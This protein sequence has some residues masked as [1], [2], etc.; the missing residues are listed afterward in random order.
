[1]PLITDSEMEEFDAAILQAGF[2]VDDF[3]IV[4]LEDE[5]TV[6]EQL[7]DETAIKQYVP[8]GTVTIQ[9][10]ST[11][12]AITYRAGNGSTWVVDFLADFYAGE[13]GKP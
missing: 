1:M 10:I 5:P 8:T 6:I 11:D 4:D 3:R 2:Q 12:G 9:R 13:Y 7:E